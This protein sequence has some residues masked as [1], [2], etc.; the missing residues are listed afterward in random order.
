MI[1][2]IIRYNLLAYYLLVAA[3]LLLSAGISLV[4]QPNAYLR[5]NGMIVLGA[6]ALLLL[7]P[8]AS[9]LRGSRDAITPPA[10]S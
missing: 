4:A 6:L 5:S 9:W 3:L 2:K 10:S 7:W 1:L 8:L